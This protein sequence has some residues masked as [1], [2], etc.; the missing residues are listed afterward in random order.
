MQLR[1][2][3]GSTLKHLES[4]CWEQLL[5]VASQHSILPPPAATSTPSGREEWGSWLPGTLPWEAHSASTRWWLNQMRVIFNMSFHHFVPL[6]LEPLTSFLHP[7]HQVK[8][9]LIYTMGSFA[10]HLYLCSELFIWIFF[11]CLWLFFLYWQQL[12][13]KKKPKHFAGRLLTSFFEVGAISETVL[14]KVEKRLKKKKSFILFPFLILKCY[15]L[16]QKQNI[17]VTWIK[18]IFFSQKL[19]LQEVKGGGGSIFFKDLP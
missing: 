6:L 4:Y 7:K 1:T 3:R 8:E 16:S 19:I 18:D 5:Q 9:L 14:K 15:K 10:V 12:S 17:L 11:S 13:F 2:V